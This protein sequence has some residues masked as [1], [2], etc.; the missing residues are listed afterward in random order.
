MRNVINSIANVTTTA[1]AVRQDRA[2]AAGL[3]TVRSFAL[4]YPR[5][6]QGPALK[7][8]SGTIGKRSS[9]PMQGEGL[10]QSGMSCLSTARL[11]RSGRLL[12]G[13][14]GTRS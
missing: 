1:I 12:S 14:L 5:L 8:W 2:V 4:H 6:H 7:L 13:S 9:E 3:D 11:S 10:R